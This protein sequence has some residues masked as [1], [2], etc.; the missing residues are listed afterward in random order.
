MKAQTKGILLAA[1]GAS[2]WGGSGAAAQYLFSTSNITT[3]WLVAIRLLTAGILLTIWSIYKKPQQI[4][5][6]ITNRFNIVILLM[7]SILGMMNSQLT[8][9][10][11]V[12][13]SNAPTATVIQY[14]QP[15]I[16]IIW[17]ALAQHKWPRRIDNISITIALI[18]TFFLVT[19]GHINTLTLTPLALFWGIWCAFAAAFYTMLPRQLLQKF[20]ALTVCGLAMLVSGIIL[21]PI[22]LTGPFPALTG[23]QWLLV[24]YIVIGGTMFS[25]TM[26]LQSIRYISPA[27]TG[28]LSAFE[29]L[30][31]TLLAVTLLGT[32]LTIVAVIGSL[33]ILL[34]TFLQAIPVD[35]MVKFLSKTKN[36]A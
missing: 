27:A 36:K 8:Y 12:K 6:I 35:R 4:H 34:T 7:F 33:L 28:I 11:A 29:P 22:L 25:Y 3:S 1:G 32:R 14:L 18:G 26:F 24:I 30:I 15:V 21:I 20:D 16:I 5:N 10:L 9:F 13:Y 31:A 23:W 2:L 19:G 17:L